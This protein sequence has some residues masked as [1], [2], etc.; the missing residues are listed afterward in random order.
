MVPGVILALIPK[1]PACLAAYV[2]IGTGL[3]ISASVAAYLRTSLA[4]LCIASLSYSAA[5]WFRRRRSRPVALAPLHTHTDLSLEETEAKGGPKSSRD[6]PLVLWGNPPW[7]SP[8]SRRAAPG[9][10]P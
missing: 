2:A 9:R 3:A 4:V 8:T 1:C 6:D 10:L 5:R 7:S